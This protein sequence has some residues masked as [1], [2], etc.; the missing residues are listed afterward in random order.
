MLAARLN[1]VDHRLQVV[2]VP[3]PEPGSGQV[4]IAVE[5]AGVCLS[6]VH[7]VQ[8]LLTPMYLD[9]DVVTLGHEVAGTIDA[10]GPGVTGW[11][12]GQRVALQAGELS[13][14]QVLTRGV[15]YDGGWAEY[16]LASVATLVPIPD[17]LPFEQAAIIPDAVSTPWG[18]VTG[19]G[20][21]RP[22]EAV[23]VWGIGGLGA[24]AVQL[25]RMIGAAPIIAVDPI[26][27]ARDR[28]LAYG[29]DLALDAAE[30]ELPVRVRSATGGHGLAAA[31][32][33][34]GEE[35]VRSQA[36]QCLGL[37]GRLVLVGLGAEPMTI[38]NPALISFMG[39]QIRGHYGSGPDDLAVL[40]GLV[41]HGRL[42]L[43]KS[44]SDVLPLSEAV[45][46]VDRLENKVGNPVRL[47]LKP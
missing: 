27:A 16:A 26:P 24:H 31:F 3:T 42:D 11:T 18:A 22:G 33:F 45:E 5:A 43:A 35:A 14:R 46:A 40:I 10:L 6:D 8:G 28:A 38:A 39:Q 29:A 20:G 13:A 34:A 4:R 23:G 21:V 44:I 25:L 19:T 2:E 9:G 47:V 15:D 12:E 1:V 41:G 17:S 32:D 7:L 36:I 30:P 37:G